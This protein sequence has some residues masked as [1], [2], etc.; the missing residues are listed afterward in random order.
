[1]QY[2]RLSQY[3]LGSSPM[4]ERLNPGTAITCKHMADA[5][6]FHKQQIERAR[7]AAKR[8]D[9]HACT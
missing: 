3:R 5:R 6:A 8:T 2:T 1:M 9:A 7:E 4:T